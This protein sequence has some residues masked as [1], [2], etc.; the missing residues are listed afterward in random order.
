[1]FIP[2]NLELKPSPIHGLGI[3]AKEDI[4]AKKYLGEYEGV[5]YS[6]K[7]FKEKYGNDTEHCY[8]A[9]RYNYILCAKENRNWISFINESKEPNCII[10]AHK[11][12]TIKDIVKGEELF[13]QYPASYPRTYT[14]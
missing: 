5:K 6:L 8:V 2:A 1:M 14:L 11:L 3:F 12:K 4:K 9:K 7:D 10:H 13:L